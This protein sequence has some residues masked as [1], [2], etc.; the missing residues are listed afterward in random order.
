VFELLG[1]SGPEAD[2]FLAE[3]AAAAKHAN[4]TLPDTASLMLKALRETGLSDAEWKELRRVLLKHADIFDEVDIDDRH[5]YGE[6][7]ADAAARIKARY[8]E[9]NAALKAAKFPHLTR[10]ALFPEEA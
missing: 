2:A 7:W 8:A 4:R 10:N 6:P 3:A 1:V 5:L 9:S